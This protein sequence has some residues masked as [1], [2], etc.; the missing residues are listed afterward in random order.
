M[1]QI[2]N[3]LYIQTQ[4]AYLRLEKE[5]LKIE[6]EKELKLQV[7]LHHLGGIFAFGNVL[8]SPFLGSAKQVMICCNGE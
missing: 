5:T 3:T 1:K 8:F 7:P 4:G 2:L 6:I